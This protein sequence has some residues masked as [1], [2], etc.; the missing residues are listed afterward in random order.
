MGSL[1]SFFVLTWTAPGQIYPWTNSFSLL[2]VYNVFWGTCSIHCLSLVF[3]VE[4][5]KD[6]GC[7]LFG[8]EVLVHGGTR[9]AFALCSALQELHVLH[10]LVL[11]WNERSLMFSRGKVLKYLV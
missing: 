7:C 5:V 3:F 2:T 4:I 1:T 6:M 10:K 8:V 11:A 9:V